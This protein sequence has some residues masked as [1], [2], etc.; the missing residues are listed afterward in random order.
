MTISSQ[1]LIDEARRLRGVPWI[2]QGRTRLGV[3]CIGLVLLAARNAGLD[4][5]NHLGIRLPA[6][7]SRSPSIDLFSLVERHCIQV[8]TEVAGALLFFQFDRDKYPRHFGI[9][10]E[11]GTMIHAEAKTRSQVVEH[12]Y[13]AHWLRWNHSIWKL[14]GVEYAP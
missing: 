14:P 5:P 8:D 13:R 2:H 10:T 3:D 9:L 11:S 7:Y 1:A 12:G 6:N 4:L